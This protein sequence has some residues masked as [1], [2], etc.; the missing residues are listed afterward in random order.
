MGGNS[1]EI[2]ADVLRLGITVRAYAVFFGGFIVIPSSPAKED[3][4]SRN[5][6][7]IWAE[8][9][10][11]ELAYNGLT[12][13]CLAPGSRSTPLAL[14]FYDHPAIQI[15]LHLDERSA[16]FFA[17]GMALAQDKPVALLC[18]SG[19]ATANFHPAIIEALMSEVPLLVLT[20]DRP[21]E[22]RH[23]GANQTVDQVKMFGDHV[24]WSLDV[25]LPQTGAPPILL[26]SLRT[27]AARVLARANGM[28]KGP[29]HI[30]F[31]FRK[32]LQSTDPQSWPHA[33]AEEKGERPFTQIMRGAL[34]PTQAQIDW[35]GEVLQNHPRGLIICGPRCPGGDFVQALSQLSAECGYPILAD[36]LSGLRFGP[37]VA[38]TAVLGGYETFLQGNQAFPPPDVILRFGA[39]PTSKW[40]NK[41]LSRSDPVYHIHIRESGSWADQDHRTRQFLQVDPIALCH[42]LAGSVTRAIDHH[43][44]QQ[45]LETESICWSTVEASLQTIGFDGSVV[46]DV[47][48]LLPTDAT[49][50]V[51][52]SLAIRHVD[53]FGQPRTEPF[54]LFAN[55]GAS[56]IDGNI[57]TGLGIA[58]VSGGPNVLLVGD[59]TFFHDSNGLMAI[60]QQAIS[61][62]TIVLLN[63]NGGGIFRRLP[64]AQFKTPFEE[65]FLTPHN[66][67][68]APLA[69]MYGIEYT[70]IVDRTAF[71][72][73]LNES[74]ATPNP[75]IIE[76]RTD[77]R[78]DESIRR[79]IIAQV[80]TALR[81]MHTNTF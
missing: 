28:K 66:L 18:T 4:L 9:F 39:V 19:T 48:D 8:I 77:S 5:P 27:L 53:Q 13:V 10:V 47:L 80:E 75:T 65:L 57:S 20:A 23:S 54:R 45:W 60:N 22:L 49:L 36:P 41:Y 24:L 58:A 34:Q 72:A 78:K 38:S 35:A 14:A 56:G 40:L 6:N 43:W 68:F 46:A 11:D 59:I 76:V 74:I 7:A 17:L 71:K 12:A 16:A 1:F 79:Q 21:P 42:D 30:N 50:F 44:Q 52:N 73:A 3:P 62:V 32:P 67:D 51:G 25:A 15:Y 26:R 61:D 2:S 33:F 31:P 70:L 55:R 64:I 63:N 37:H 81:N 29:V 69:A